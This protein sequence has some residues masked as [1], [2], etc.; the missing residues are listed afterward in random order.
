MAKILKPFKKSEGKTAKDERIEAAEKAAN[1][2]LKAFV[3]QLQTKHNITVSPTIITSLDTI[4][5]Y[6]PLKATIDCVSNERFK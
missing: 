3:E 1:D 5:G 2:E 6:R 4:R